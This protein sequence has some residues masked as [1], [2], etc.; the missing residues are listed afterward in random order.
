MAGGG[1]PFNMA[2]PLV[3]A[4]DRRKPVSPRRALCGASPLEGANTC[5]SG[6]QREE[7]R[8]FG[9]PPSI[10][11]KAFLDVNRFVVAESQETG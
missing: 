3:A 11:G 8:A 7:N 2:S 10:E 6:R 5:A 1:V 4:G 9:Q